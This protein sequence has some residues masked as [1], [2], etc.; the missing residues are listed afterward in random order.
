MAVQ[1]AKKI[2]GR[3][4]GHQYERQLAALFRELGFT[5]CATSRYCSK[6][7]DDMKV[8]L[9]NTGPFFLQAKAVEKLGSIH[10][11]LESMPKNGKTNLVFHKRNRKGTVVSMKQEDFIKILKILIDNNLICTK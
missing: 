3:V 7:L 5:D 9:A 8:D 2:N 10:D 11:I 6:Q 4:K 1:K